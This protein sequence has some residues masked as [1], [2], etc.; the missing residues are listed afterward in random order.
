MGRID[1]RLAELG[2][3]VPAG[4]RPDRGKPFLP[5][6]MDG[7]MLYLSGQLPDIDGE[8]IVRGQV[9][10]EVTVDAG[11]AAAERVARNLV[12]A[13]RL[14]LGDLD[15][16]DRFVK[17][18]GFVNS[19]PGFDEQ[20]AVINGASELFVEIWGDRGLHARSAVG[21]AALPR[22]VPVEI[23]AIIRVRS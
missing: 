22:R 1:E 19:A 10:A 3:H 17:L 4:S 5:W 11:R 9:G 14:A 23:E 18:L 20:P 21:V 16:V 7:P 12:A 6:V 15:R 13:I 8:P 2:L